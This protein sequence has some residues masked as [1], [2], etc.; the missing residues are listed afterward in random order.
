MKKIA[1]EA[2]LLFEKEKTGVGW[3]AAKIIHTLIQNKEYE[4]YLNYSCNLNLLRIGRKREKKIINQYE[5]NNVHFVK[6]SFIKWLTVRLFGKLVR[7]PYS[8]MFGKNADITQF[9]NYYVPRGVHGKVVTIVHDMAYLA[10]P[11]CVADANIIWLQK[12]LKDSCDRSDHIAVSSEFTKKELIKYLK[13]EE[14][15]I[16]VIYSGIDKKNM[17]DDSRIDNAYLEELNISGSYI[18]FVGT[19]EPR[20]N[21]QIIIKAFEKICEEYSQDMSLVLAGKMG[22]K[23]KEILDSIENFPFQGRIIITGYVSE[24]EKRTL[25]KNAALFVFPSKYEG[26]GIPPLEAMASG[27]PVITS[28]YASL[29]EVVGD[30]AIKVNSDDIEELYQAMRAVLDNK[31][32]REDLIE[33]G[34][35]QAEKFPWECVAERLLNI[36]RKDI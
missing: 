28:N 36:Y 19:I 4:F 27:V 9:F 32:L 3:H 24:K 29:P 20:K 12:N 26:F 22:W 33:K 34:F 17:N 2:E 10:C 13:I 23:N 1:L 35:L 15:K 6:A 8:F 5:E 21:V 31:T 16:S 11:E 30:A 14:E 18:L 7:N 25:Y